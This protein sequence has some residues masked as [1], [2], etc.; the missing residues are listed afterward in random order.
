MASILTT[1]DEVGKRGSQ[2]QKLL[3]PI[4]RISDGPAGAALFGGRV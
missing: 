2:I 1:I 3:R 4:S